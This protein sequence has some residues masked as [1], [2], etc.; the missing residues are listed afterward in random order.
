VAQQPGFDVIPATVADAGEAAAWRFLEFFAANLPND[1]TRRAYDRA[2]LRFFAWT[3]EKGL[4]L[5][6]IRA[7]HVAAYVKSLEARHSVPSVKQQLA[8]VRMLFDFLVVGQILP[9]NP[10]TSVRGPGD[11]AIQGPVALQPRR[12]RRVIWERSA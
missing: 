10:A 1:N 8:A 12:R 4:T 9:M 3:K 7:P 5:G 6:T 11:S 2:A